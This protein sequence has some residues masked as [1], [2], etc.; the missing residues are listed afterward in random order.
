MKF[1]SVA[2]L[3][4]VLATVSMA[5]PQP[6]QFCSEADRFG[7]VQ[8]T[9]NNLVPGDVCILL[10]LSSF[11]KLTED[12][13]QDLYHPYRLCMR[14]QQR[15][16]AKIPRLLPWGPLC[17]Q[18]RPPGTHPPRPSGVCSSK[19]FQPECFYHIHWSSEYLLL[20][21]PYDPLKL[22]LRFVDTEMGRIR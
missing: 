17:F 6:R 3:T 9:P 8:I 22:D 5:A 2:L 11:Q 13:S 18:Q 16:H 7:I 19:C 21:L 20:Q 10:R 1:S 12:P 15:S 14:Y 4:S